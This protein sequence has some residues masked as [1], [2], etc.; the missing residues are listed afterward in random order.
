MLYLVKEV[1]GGLGRIF[2][3]KVKRPPSIVTPKGDS[4]FRSNH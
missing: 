1:E 2:P 4:K 3:T